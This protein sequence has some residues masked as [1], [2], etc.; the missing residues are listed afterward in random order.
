MLVTISVYIETTHT[1]RRY[2]RKGNSNMSK[3]NKTLHLNKKMKEYTY[4]GRKFYAKDDT[5][6]RSYIELVSLREA[7]K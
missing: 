6:A 7:R 3:K 5:D 2:L 1:Q 4:E